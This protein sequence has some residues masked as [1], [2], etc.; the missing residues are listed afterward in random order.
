SFSGASFT[1]TEYLGDADFCEAKFTG[2]LIMDHAKFTGDAHFHR[3]SFDS[4]SF[5]KASFAKAA[6]FGRSAFSRN[7]TFRGAV[8]KQEANFGGIRSGGDF[9]VEFATFLKLPN[10]DDAS[11]SARANPDP[12]ILA[13]P[14]PKKRSKEPRYYEISGDYT[15][16]GPVEWEF[17]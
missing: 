3:A 11:F 1:E 2:D 6:H 14:K 8:F 17:V 15:R 4:A 7:T 5:R 12:R 13:E 16:E 10:F 9:E